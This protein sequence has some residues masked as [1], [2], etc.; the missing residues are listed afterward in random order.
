MLVA[1]L[2][3]DVH[4]Y[5]AESGDFGGEGGE[6]VVVLSGGA[7]SVACFRLQDGEEVG[8]P[9]SVVGL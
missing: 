8:A 4:C 6:G 2:I 9:F 3:V 5:G 1:S 7:G